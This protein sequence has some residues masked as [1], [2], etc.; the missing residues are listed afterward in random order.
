MKTLHDPLRLETTDDWHNG[1]PVYKILDNLI[2]A[3][4]DK[5][6]D[7]IIK[8]SAG[9][10]TDFAS[11]PRF[12]WRVFPPAGK[13]GKAA[14]IHDFLYRFKT[15][16]NRKDADYIFWLAMGELG[17]PDWKRWCIWKAVRL[18]GKTTWN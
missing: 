14:I 7:L 1:R 17:V 4:G 10:T 5:F 9:F 6:N 2:Y 12:F 3:P 18:F 11:I 8:V 13:Y 16:I 15:G